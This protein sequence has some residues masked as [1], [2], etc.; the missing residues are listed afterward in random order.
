MNEAIFKEISQL[1][2]F[3]NNNLLFWIILKII[4]EYEFKTYSL[5]HNS[6]TY[7]YISL[8]CTG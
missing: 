1:A 4:P 2:S 8:I 7:N 3:I 6:F 5:L